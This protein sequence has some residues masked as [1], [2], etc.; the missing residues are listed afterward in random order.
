MTEHYC[1]SPTWL[2]VGRQ[3]FRLGR[4]FNPVSPAATFQFDQPAA[5]VVADI[6]IGNASPGR[7]AALMDPERNVSKTQQQPDNLLRGRRRSGEVR[8]ALILSDT[9]RA[10]AA[11]ECQQNRDDGP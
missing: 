5:D 4:R 1:A 8:V 3:Y 6:G 9:A 7:R 11:K 2:S 10:A